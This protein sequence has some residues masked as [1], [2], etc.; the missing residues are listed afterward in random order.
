M[1][2]TACGSRMPCPDCGSSDSI[3]AFLNVDSD[4]GMK[5]YSSFCFGKC[6]CQKGDPYA[7]KSAPLAK[8]KT[9]EQ[10]EE[11]VEDIRKCKIFEVPSSYRSIP[12]KYYKRWGCRMLVSEYD[13]KTPHAIAFPYSNQGK[14][15]GWKARAFKLNSRGKK[16][17]W[18]IGNT[19]NCDVF[20]LVRA[21]RLGGDTIWFTEGEFDSIALDYCLSLVGESAN[22]PVVSLT[23]GGGGIANN[24]AHI[25]SRVRNRFKYK[26]F[27]LDDD[28]VGHK[29]ENIALKT[30]PEAIIIKKPSNCKDANDAVEAGKAIEMGNLALN[31][32]R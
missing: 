26:V 15:V 18:A 5:W 27:V 13:G 28:A 2:S 20:G 31:F 9:K 25:E 14:L 4:L 10:L 30:W 23:D 22:Y 7:G 21:L 16:V 29:A 6:Y 8:I 3:Q 17:F 1:A 19:K 11:E 24:L 12:S 32:D